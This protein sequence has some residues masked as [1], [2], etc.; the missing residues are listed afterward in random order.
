MPRSRPRWRRLLLLALE[1]LVADRVQPQL[2]ALVVL[3]GVDEEAERGA[4]RE[5]VVGKEVDAA[6]LGGV[7]AEVGGRGRDHPLLEEHRLGHPER[8]PVGHAAGRL[9]RVVALRGH[10]PDRHVVAGER[11]VQQPDLELARLGV[12]EERALVGV[13]VHPHG[14]DLAVGAQRHLGVEV[15]VAAEPRRGQ[16]AGLVLDPL[17]RLADQDRGQDRRDVAGVDRHL[18]AEPAADV[19][20]HDPD[21]VLG[22]LRHERDGRP[23]DV[24]R[25]RRHVDG[26]LS[27]ARVV[28]GDRAAALDR[29][30][31]AARVVQ[32]QRGHDVGL[33]ERPLGGRGVADLPPVAGVVGLAF[34]VVADDR[35]VGRGRLL[36]V[37]DRGQRLVL[38]VDRLAPVLGDVR[39]VGDDDA[40]LLALEAHLVGGQHRLG[41]VGQRR[42]PR[43]VALGHHLAGEHQPDAGDLPGLRRVDGLDAGVR[44]RAAQDLHVQHAGQVD[45]VDVVAAAA[46]EPGVLDPAAARAQTTDLDFVERGHAVSPRSLRA[47]H[48]TALTMFW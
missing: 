29:R 10:V 28:V 46:H 14:E 2:Q 21:H 20:R 1:L 33:R 17:H 34:L 39:V 25:L 16:V 27:G 5:L 7:D 35:R 37:D 4:V 19:R 13:G 3:A 8:A 22:Q 38:D 15:H 24:R 36:G 43:E 42:H 45:V 40:H 11:R 12:G 41:V 23:D 47:A 31:V 26:E 44:Q 30:R 9:V 6:D 32:L 18:V 48:S